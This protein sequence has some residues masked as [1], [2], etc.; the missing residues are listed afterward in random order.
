MTIDRAEAVRTALRLLDAEGLD[1]LSVRRIASE[2]GVQA[3][4]L[5]WHFTNKRELLDYLTDLILAPV[6]EA[7]KVPADPADWPEWL[8]RTA[9]DMRL[10]LIAHRDGARVALG[11]GLGRAISLGTLVDRTVQVLHAAGFNLTDASRAAATFLWLVV[12]RTVEEQ[13]LPDLDAATLR[14]A[15]RLYPNVARAMSERQANGDTQ[16]AAFG[17]GIAIMITGLRTMLDESAG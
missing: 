12:G 15:G 17:Y 6:A 8:R 7:A 9:H 10:A 16:Q 13:T 14:H 4:A 11:A 5:Y 1:K 3:P 2:L